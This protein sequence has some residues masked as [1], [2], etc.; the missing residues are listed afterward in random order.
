MVGLVFRVRGIVG[1]ELTEI[2]ATPKQSATF[3]PFGSNRVLL[4]ATYYPVRACIT[5]DKI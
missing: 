2:R 5:I 3:R 4:A 1:I